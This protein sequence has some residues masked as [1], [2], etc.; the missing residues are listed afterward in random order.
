MRL[1][2][3]FNKCRTEAI[4]RS[5]LDLIDL[6]LMLMLMVIAFTYSQSWF[7]YSVRSF[8]YFLLA[9]NFQASSKRW[10]LQKKRY[11]LSDALGNCVCQILLQQVI[12]CC[13]TRQIQLAHRKTSPRS[14]LHHCLYRGQIT[15]RWNGYRGG[16]GDIVG[17]DLSKLSRV[18]YIVVKV[19]RQTNADG[20]T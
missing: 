13:A 5:R 6:M 7:R 19:P 17:K 11:G 14:W 4:Q 8:S 16:R 2:V 20:F 12:P 18:R 3:F 1:I 15:W 9:T 10:C